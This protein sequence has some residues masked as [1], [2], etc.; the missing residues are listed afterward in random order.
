MTRKLDEGAISQIERALTERFGDP[1]AN[2]V[3]PKPI[4]PTL[5]E[6]CGCMQELEEEEEACSE[7]GMMQDELY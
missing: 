7:C 2:V 6:G 4:G 5:C 3:I 1:I